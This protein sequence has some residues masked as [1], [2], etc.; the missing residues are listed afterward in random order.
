M[1]G[2][3]VSLPF[4]AA[5][6]RLAAGDRS[7]GRGLE[8]LNAVEHL[9]ISDTEVTASVYGSSEYTVCLVIGDQRL[10][11]GCTCPYG[12]DG[13]FCKHCV[14]VG[15]S[16][17]EMGDE[18]PRHLEAARVQQQAVDAWL[19]SLSKEELLAELR[20]LLDENRE[21]RQRFE[22]RAAAMNTDALAIGAP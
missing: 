22:L 21:L 3:P 8:Y 16:V 13:F 14:A 11:G 9:E 18:L 2:M 20:G 17:L 10:S 6:I 15:L 7:Y 4:T 5:D 19:Q 1:V 12:R